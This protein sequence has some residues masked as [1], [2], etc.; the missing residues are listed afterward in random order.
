MHEVGGSRFPFEWVPFGVCGVD[1]DLLQHDATGK[2][3]V[4]I[5]DGIFVSNVDVSNRQLKKIKVQHVMF[6]YPFINLFI[7]S[8][9]VIV[10]LKHHEGTYIT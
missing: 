6:I 10:S 2:R 5:G 9:T 1:G 7:Y 8:Q 3:V 4:S